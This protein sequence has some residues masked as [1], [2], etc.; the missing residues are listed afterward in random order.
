[1]RSARPAMRSVRPAM[2]SA[3]TGSLVFD[4]MA[5]KLPALLD[6]MVRQQQR[7]FNTIFPVIGR[8]SNFHCLM[9]FIDC[10]MAIIQMRL[11]KHS[12]FSDVKNLKFIF[13]IRSIKNA[14]YMIDEIDRAR[15]L[16]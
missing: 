16:C 4:V 7:F 14:A 5:L 11:T 3:Q 13:K 6:L 10:S 15:R 9:R 12:L 1:M 2:R 8:R